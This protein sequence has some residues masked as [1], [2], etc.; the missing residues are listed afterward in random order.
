MQPQVRYLAIQILL[1]HVD[2]KARVERQLKR[3]ILEVLSRCVG[4]ASDESIGNQLVMYT[5]FIE[6]VMLIPKSVHI[7]N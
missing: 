3:S 7:Y 6:L 5:T 4:V 1:S 2:S